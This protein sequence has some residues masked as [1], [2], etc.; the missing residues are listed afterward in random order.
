VGQR[1]RV[2]VKVGERPAITIPTR[3]VATR[4]GVDYVRVLDKS[5]HAQDVAVQLAPGPDAS[6]VEVLS[7]VTGGDV[8]VA[9]RA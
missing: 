5:G 4:Y 3:F 6:R 7:G 2:M 1:V 9:P 8:I